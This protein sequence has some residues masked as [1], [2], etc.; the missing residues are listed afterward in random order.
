MAPK[1]AATPSD[2]P[3]SKRSNKMM[4]LEENVKLLDKC[5][6]HNLSNCAVGKLFG[7]NESTVRSI[8][9]NEAKIK[10]ALAATASPSAKQ[11]SQIRDSAM[12]KMES[13]LFVWIADHNKKGNPIDSNEIRAKVKSLYEKLTSHKTSTSAETGCPATSHPEF[14][15]SKGWYDKFKRRFP[16]TT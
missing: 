1:R 3:S 14:I 5:K 16:C 12:S 15:V 11:V 8:K 9:K 4:N 6:S 10:A 13:A 7:I 2:E